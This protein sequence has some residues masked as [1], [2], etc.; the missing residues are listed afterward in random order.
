MTGKNGSEIAWRP[1]RAAVDA[2][3]VMRFAAS[4]GLN[5]F[6]ALELLA[7]SDPERFW[8]AAVAWLG[9]DFA[10][11]FSHV[12]SDGDSAWCRWFVGGRLNAAEI[13]VDAPARSD[14]S[15]PAVVWEDESGESITWSR[16]ELRENVDALADVLIRRGVGPGDSVGLYLP[17]APEAVAALFAVAKIGAVAVPLFS[18]FG[19]DA[20]AVRLGDAKAK[21]VVTADRTIR[22]GERIGMLAVVLEAIANVPNVATVVAARRGT[23]E[24]PA[25]GRVVAWPDTTALQ[26]LTTTPLD[27]EHPLLIAYT[28]GTT[29]RPKAAV[30][31]HGGFTAKIA[32]EHAFQLDV[33]EGDRLLWLTDVGWIMGAHTM[34]GALARRATLVLLEGAPDYPTDGRVWAVAARHRATVLGV[35]PTLVRVLASRDRS[36]PERHD[37]SALRI[38]G[39]TGEPWS[40]RPWHWFL[41]NVGGGRCPIINMSGGTEVGALLSTHPVSPLKPMSVGGPALGVAA[42]VFG[43]DGA[44]VRDRVGELVCTAPIPSMTRG[45]L[46]DPQRYLDTYWSRW[47]G[48][49]VHG[50]WASIDEDGHW[51]L[52]GRSDDTINLAGKRVG[53]AEVESALSGHSSV[54]EAAVVGLPDPDKGEALVAFVVP[55]AG[56]TADDMLRDEL[57]QLVAERL[58]RA[59]RP[60]A[61]RFV[62]ALPKT[63][64]AKVLRRSIRAVASG[65][66]PGD[67]SAIDDVAALDAIRAAW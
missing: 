58:G 46:G 3:N 47:P 65:T 42:D 31:V 5:D 32:A 45:L 51:F 26:A 41:D 49:W 37:L 17:M 13:C 61:V 57:S 52:H 11:P 30:H 18:G 55:I 40:E 12:R 62:T 48:V 8:S 35:S 44:P 54:A 22:R 29:G 19:P 66:E 7:G 6:A 63:R 39:S 56:S 36:A 59:F 16:E 10:Q 43:D 21:A 20:I 25:V 67:L 27:S 34:I 53:P 2:A 60:A 33:K 64:T 28:S 24:L 15:A 38:L 1:T 9:I 4:L 23:D 50:D 14:P